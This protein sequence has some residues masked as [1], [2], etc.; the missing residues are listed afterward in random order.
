MEGIPKTVIDLSGQSTFF[1]SRSF[2]YI[3]R[4]VSYQFWKLNWI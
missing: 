4:F 1:E 3:T 2:L